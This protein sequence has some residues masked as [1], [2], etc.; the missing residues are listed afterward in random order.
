M[1]Y[2]LF[3]FDGSLLHITAVIT[4]LLTIGFIV[5]MV[6]SE[7]FKYRY[8]SSY[9]FITIGLIAVTVLAFFG[10]DYLNSPIDSTD[11][12]VLEKAYA[13]SFK[14]PNGEV[15]RKQLDNLAK[16]NGVVTIPELSYSGDELHKDYINKSD[17]NSLAKTFNSIK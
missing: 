4:A 1:K 7:S 12:V 6:T 10:G 14:M 13:E 11:A 2:F 16:D 8:I 5:K 15:F 9:K 17:W 3:G